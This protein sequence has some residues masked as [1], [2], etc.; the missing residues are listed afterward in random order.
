MFGLKNR[1]G[2]AVLVAAVLIISMG[3]SVF[4]VEVVRYEFENNLLDTASGGAVNDNL[5]AFDN[6]KNT[7]GVTTN[8]EPGV[9][10]MAAARQR[11]RRRVIDLHGRNVSQG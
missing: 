8:Y 5:T 4:A 3:G 2:F 10:G 11:R 7:I 1:W 6:G 9:I